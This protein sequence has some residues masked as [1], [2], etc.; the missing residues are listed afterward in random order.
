MAVLT[1][2]A[3]VFAINSAIK[4]GR[5]V[6]RAYAKNLKSKELILPL[7]TF[8]GEPNAM[9]AEEFFSKDDTSTGGLQ[10]V[11]RIERLGKLHEIHL[12]IGLT[13]DESGEYVEYYKLFWDLQKED[14]LKAD[15]A[16][17]HTEDLVAL[18]RIR[19]WETGKEPPT[20]P[21]QLVAGT[22]V[23]IGI[24]Y[25]NQVPGA[26]NTGSSHGRIMKSFLSAIDEV[27]FSDAKEFKSSA[28]RI[29]PKL[30]ISAA[31]AIGELSSEVSA[32]VKLQAF[33]KATSKGIAEDIFKR[34]KRGEDEEESIQWGQMLL[35]S[36]VKN[37]GHYVFNS[38]DQLF[39]TTEGQSLLIQ[40]TGTAFLEAILDAPNDQLNLRNAF[41]TDTLDKVVRAA[42]G[43]V[44]ECPELIEKRHHG[45]KAIISG[46]A[47]VLAAHPVLK[48]RPDLLPELVRLI[49][50][51]TAQNFDLLWGPAA[52]DGEHLL[53]MAIQQI[54]F[55]IS[56]PPVDG[57][58]RPQLSKT[59][60]LDVAANLLD[61]VVKNPAWVKDK[62]QDKPMLQEVL[63]S[64]FD[65][66]ENIPKEHRLNIRVINHVIRLSIRSAV[67]SRAI[68]GRIQWADDAQE[69]TIL[70]KALD[71][72]FHYVDHLDDTKGADHV[73]LLISLLEY[74][75]EVIISK[76]PNAKGLI[77]A[78]LVLF[79]TP[80]IDYAGGFNRELADQI[81]NAALKVL[82]ERPE[83]AT[84]HEALQAILAGVA[85]AREASSF[86]KAGILPELL[87]LSLEHTARNAA[88]VIPG[89]HGQPRYLITLALQ[90][91]L[92]A[93]S[94][95]PDAGHWQ[96]QLTITQLLQ[97]VNN[98]FDEVVQYPDWVIGSTGEPL[99]GAALE[100]VFDA[101]RHLPKDQRLT[102][103]ALQLVLQMSLRAITRNQALLDRIHWGTE[104]EE[105]VL[106]NKA[107][108]LVFAYVFPAGSPASIDK[109]AQLL[110]LLEY[111]LDMVVA[112]YPDKRAL[113][114]LSLIFFKD[115]EFD[116]AGGFRKEQAEKL[117]YAALRVFAEH[118]ELV[119]KDAV[120]QKILGD[121]AAALKASK[122]PM[123]ELLPELF[124]IALENTAG[125][126]GRIMNLKPDG[127]K[128][129]IAVAIEQTL[130]AIA[131]KP[132]R[133]K[134]KPA[135]SPEQVLGIV[136]T[137]IEET[138]LHPQWVRND[139]L[140]L[141]VLEAVF[142]ALECIPDGKDIPYETV[143]FLIEKS[144]EA[145]AV[146]QQM[147][148][149]EIPMATGGEKKL[150]LT[151]S[152]ECVFI[153]LYDKNNQSAGSWTLT[154]APAIQAI[155]EFFL[156]GI[157]KG[158]V[159][160]PTIDASVDKIKQA[161]QAINNNLQ[162][163][164]EGLLEELERR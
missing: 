156:M 6:Q 39:D 161:V 121:T 93:V 154:Q 38:T 140:I 13:P 72:V 41:T 37:A 162:F 105:V 69:K 107:L 35:R 120:F 88:L 36:M 97:L 16:R 18:L 102:P 53:L 108:D 112:Q 150:A 40:S 4:L 66:L 32:D 55:E 104:V 141:V 64:V 113:L 61:D 96:P 83:L 17:L 145:V 109:T 159:D 114:L 92:T 148:T 131:A 110:D 30:F 94:E 87:R 20:T 89:E 3:I 28:E 56:R 51:H 43:A 23:E 26:L 101:F 33:I 158:P 155:V 49:L 127:P 130:R 58:W 29:V 160:K 46:V 129:I 77:L 85:G 12:N 42:L 134:W 122:L 124:R 68:L 100:A 147:I 62:V 44:A 138:L 65:A 81:I 99:L 74:I 78:D 146:R 45:V 163:T 75:L 8:S 60:L 136:N 125:Q 71:L 115:P 116:L 137:V 118:P 117:S 22:L 95:K 123:P 27:T 57:K 133:G 139:K 73:P 144:L 86:R 50:E 14:Q 157:A 119:S 10:F 15:D 135:L 47:R 52:P 91:I 143:K 54:L 63:A 2:E 7:P 80:G 31:E 19:Q 149:I 151:Y 132:K 98:L 103:D 9:R 164:V 70:N 1:A 11:R 48:N 25:F 76:H 82:N 59:Q 153:E 106:L 5:N 90:Q 111:A 126:V 142:R 79:K 152:L 34:S 128:N 67:T 84:N 24:D 21:L